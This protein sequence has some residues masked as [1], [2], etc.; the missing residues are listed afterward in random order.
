MFFFTSSR[1]NYLGKAYQLE[2]K[3]KN[4]KKYGTRNF[5]HKLNSFAKIFLKKLAST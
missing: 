1:D 3:K 5:Q 4:M 2:L